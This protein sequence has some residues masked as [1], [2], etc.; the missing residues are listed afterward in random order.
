M[1]NIRRFAMLLVLAA[2]APGCRDQEGAQP[3]GSPP[4][5]PAKAPAHDRRLFV[6]GLD[7]ADER[8]VSQGIAA[9]R[10]P[11]FD[12]MIREGCSGPLRTHRPILSPILWTTMAT[13]LTPDRHGVLD[14]V[15]QEASGRVVPITS[16]SRRA[17]AFWEILGAAGFKC[18]IVGWLATFPVRPLNGFVISDRFTLHPFG[19][20]V[21]PP[22]TDRSGTTYPPGLDE[23]LRETLVSPA[24]ITDAELASTF[25]APTVPAGEDAPQRRELRVIEAAARTYTA[26]ALRLDEREKPDLL[27]VYFEAIDRLMHLFGAAMAPPLPGTAKGMADRY[28]HAVE[29]FY[30]AMDR[31]LGEFMTEAGEEGTVLVI[32]DHGFKIGDERPQHPALRSDVFAAEWHRDPG[33]VVAW[34]RG[35]LRGAKI[36][37]ADIYDVTPTLLAYFGVPAS[38]SMR[39]HVLVGLFEP[40]FLPPLGPRVHDYPM[41]EPAGRPGSDAAPTAGTAPSGAG[42]RQDGPRRRRSSRTSARWDMSVAA[43]RRPRT[44]RPRISRPSTSRRSS[45]IA[46]SRSTPRF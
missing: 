7:A 25:G 44:A 39:G 46:R 29:R 28:G 30:A 4:K 33:I 24:A 14:F 38:E 6:V 42:S 12:R 13:G 20:G 18:G 22:N 41:A 32:S 34:G 23:R 10:L 3:P 5:A 16:R 43:A 17:P 40:G 45:S 35:V 11:N 26:A 36:Q 1:F 9:G 19:D 31:R 21:E 15:E 37:D 2:L 27:A 8:L